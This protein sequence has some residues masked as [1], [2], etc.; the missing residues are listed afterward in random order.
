MVTFED[1]RKSFSKAEEDIKYAELSIDSLASAE[2]SHCNPGVNPRGIVVPSVNELRYA[3]KH[4]SDALAEEIS[5]Q[6]KAEHIDKAIRHCVRAR[7][8]ALKA[9]VYFLGQHFQRF[10][11]DYRLTNLPSEVRAHQ[12][13]LHSKFV[14]IFWEIAQS[15]TDRTDTECDVLRAKVQE[16][17]G[18]Y[19]EVEK[20]R[21]VFNQLLYENRKHDRVS[22]VLW[23]VGIIISV[24]SGIVIG[25]FF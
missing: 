13:D 20:Q 7:L 25:K 21:D 8:D 9:T 23:I 15:H 4:L 11:Q 19:L 6:Q 12:N 16:L 18:F 3:A 2:D 14:G 22:T 5:G 1:F 17:H 10:S 24:I